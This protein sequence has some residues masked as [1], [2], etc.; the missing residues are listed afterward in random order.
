MDYFRQD[1]RFALRRLLRSPG[2]AAVAI[3]TLALGIGANTTVFSAVNTLILRPLPVERPDQLVFF[4]TPRGGSNQSY[5]NYK[6]FRDRN[7]VLSGLVAS[8]IASIGLTQGGKNAHAWGYL[9]SGNYFDVLGVK[10]LIGRAFTPADDLKRGGHPVAVLSYTGWQRRFAG[11]PNVVGKTVKLNALDY[12]IVGVTPKGFIG[13]ELFFTPELFVPMA[14]Q[15]QIEPGNSWLDNLGTHNIWVVG[16]LKPGVTKQQA[17]AALNTIAAQLGREHPSEN[18]GLK[19]VLSPPGFVGNTLRGAIVGFATVL[20]GVAGLVLLIACTN[21]ASL[22]LARA[23]DRRK[24]IAIQLALGAGRKQL[25]RQ[26]LTESFLLSS[27][28]AVAGLLLARW[29]VTLFMAWQPPIDFPINTTLIV[30]TRVL[31]FTAGLAIL[32]TLLFGLAPALQSTRTELVPSL[33]G[34]PPSERMRRW[35]LRDVLVTAQIT[36]SVILLVA[37]VLV[38]RSLQ[39]ALTV[40]IGFNPQNAVTAGFELSLHGYDEPRGRE[41]QRRIIEKVRNLPGIESASVINGVPLGMD[42]S[43]RSIVVEGRPEP[44]A[45]ERPSAM[46]YETAPGYFHTMQTALLAGRDFNENDRSNRPHVAIVNQAFAAQIF[47]GENALGKRVRAGGDSVEIVGIVEDGKYLSLSEGKTPVIFR[48]IT[49]A[50]NSD[51]FVVARARIPADQALREVQRAILDLDSSMV[52]IESGSLYDHLRLPLFPARLAASIL[53]AFG[54]L[55][56]LLA[57][58]GIYG[59]VA[60]SVSQRTRELGI[61]IAIGASKA[62]V[63]TVVLQRTAML[64]AIGGILGTLTAM[65]VGGLCSP[66]LYGVNPKDPGTF[67][68]AFGMMALVAF[69]ASWIP[70]RRAMGLDPLAALRQD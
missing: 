40:H 11:D 52:F 20:M 43:T 38:V 62:H 41:F 44:R 28:G 27:T 66:V 24:E 12:T 5:P 33:K 26:L 68:L 10:A 7:Q 2:F 34:D 58:T 56:I 9:V 39:Q 45:S 8:R 60:Y 55:A 36:L 63:F 18:E 37:S 25:V 29:L 57:A 61:R 31:L 17:E 50:Y 51:T 22:L 35:H 64:L 42:V 14:M 13:T 47:P 46:S 53:G 49:Q 6:A 23:A 65:A 4:N 19:I 48:A 15:A 21:L 32:T 70:A 54:G 3:I 16:R 1:L 67:A 59:V 69:A 30:D